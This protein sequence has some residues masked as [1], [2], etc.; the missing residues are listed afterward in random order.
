ML[1]LKNLA[2]NYQLMHQKL[3]F[4]F[5]SRTPY[6]ISSLRSSKVDFTAS[7][8]E[9]TLLC[10]FLLESS[11]ISGISLHGSIHSCFFW[12]GDRAWD[13]KF[14]FN[15]FSETILHFRILGFYGSKDISASPKIRSTENYISKVFIFNGKI[16]F[17]ISYTWKML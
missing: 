17:K 3:F 13:L 1:K 2:I 7:Q 4:K 16:N 15:S 11:S 12:L 14:Q 9:D 8:Q 6:H 5:D 10:F